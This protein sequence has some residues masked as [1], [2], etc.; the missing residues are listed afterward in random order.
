MNGQISFNPKT[1]T[2]TYPDGQ[3]E[4]LE[5]YNERKYRYE[6]IQSLQDALE[7]MKVLY[8]TPGCLTKQEYLDAKRKIQE[9]F[10]FWEANIFLEFD[11]K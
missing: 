8:Q 5:Q 6:Y 4:T 2:F 10:D 11:D 7:Q 9:E 1:E 3:I